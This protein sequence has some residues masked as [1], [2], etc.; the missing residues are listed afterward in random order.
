VV[1]AECTDGLRIGIKD[2][3]Q[4]TKRIC[5]FSFHCYR[6]LRIDILYYICPPPSE[7]NPR[8]CGYKVATDT[9]CNDM[10]PNL[11]QY[12]TVRCAT[13]WTISPPS[14]WLILGIH[15][16]LIIYFMSGSVSNKSRYAVCPV[17]RKGLLNSKS[18]GEAK[19]SF[20]GLWQLKSFACCGPAQGS[21]MQ[22]H[23]LNHLL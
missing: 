5:A 12:C 8:H 21:T 13:K 9:F 17:Y 3:P 10:S 1:S 19:T 14:V 22:Y 4:V 7:A 23:L 6:L 11:L 16:C 15:K 2:P 20:Y 18:V